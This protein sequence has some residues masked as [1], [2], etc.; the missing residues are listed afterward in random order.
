M[1]VRSGRA[2][3]DVAMAAHQLA[4]QGLRAER[5]E[6]I[7]MYRRRH[8]ELLRRWNAGELTPRDLRVELVDYYTRTGEPELEKR[9][10]QQTSD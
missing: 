6:Q 10:F 3:D 1:S 2:S 4:Q 8:A 9:F 5:V 7:G